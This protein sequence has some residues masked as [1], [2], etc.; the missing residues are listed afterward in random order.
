MPDRREAGSWT[1]I[2]LAASLLFSSLCYARSTIVTDSIAVPSRV[3]AERGAAGVQGPTDKIVFRS[4][5]LGEERTV[6]VRVPERY[7]RSSKSYPVLYVLDGE[8]HFDLAASSARYLSE[9][10]ASDTLIPEI[11]VVGIVN[12]D[13]D[14]DY[15]PTRC[16][17][18]EG[19][20]F[21]T[22]G[23]SGRF[24][25]F[26]T[27]ELI[28]LI[29]SRYRTSP[30]RI[31]SGWSFG[32]LFTV[33]TFMKSP[34]QFNAY[35]AISPSLWWDHDL[36]LKDYSG[37]KPGSPVKLV[38]T[39]GTEEEGG[40]THTATTKLAGMLEGKPVENLVFRLLVMD[41]LG[42]NLS[43]PR[44]FCEGL[45]A[46]FSDWLA[47]E[48]VVARGMDAVKDYYASLSRRYG[49]EVEIPRDILMTLAWNLYGE[50]K[51]DEATE[52]FKEGIEKYPLHSLGH[53][54]LGR[55]YQRTERPQLAQELYEEALALEM[56]REVPDGVNLRM[57]RQALGEVRSQL[58]ESG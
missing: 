40:W 56:E 38:M 45:R 24:R 42:H 22:S 33:E 44:G 25:Q 9:C 26:L 4:R 50:K 29:E 27:E 47:P 51:V 15:T 13:R 11:I 48:G 10:G 34:S 7:A 31:L 8:W 5:I 23:A 41:R 28:P 3:P 54:Y 19:M 46:L 57:Y 2:L 35:L 36:L 55:V 21:P 53:Y 58:G 18:Y 32:G 49:H 14:R 37:E 30:F 6:Y 20:S 43:V 52:V 1:R 17:E 39:I 12:V 16:A